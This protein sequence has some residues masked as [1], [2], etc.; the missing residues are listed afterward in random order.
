MS[1]NLYNVYVLKGVKKLQHFYR[2]HETTKMFAY[3][4]EKA[5]AISGTLVLITRILKARGQ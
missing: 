4:E 1:G 2:G 5:N 3:D